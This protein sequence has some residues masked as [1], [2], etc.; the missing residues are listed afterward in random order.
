MKFSQEEI[1]CI[2]FAIVSNRKVFD[3]N[4]IEEKRNIHKFH[5]EL[6]SFDLLLFFYI[7]IFN[8]AQHVLFFSRLSRSLAHSYKKKQTNLGILK[9]SNSLVQASNSSCRFTLWNKKWLKMS[10]WHSRFITGSLFFD[11]VAF[12]VPFSSRL[13]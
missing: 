8:R 10:S 4:D 11:V 1:S 12:I 5:V 13:I 9:K 6:W 2:F 7:I 3:E